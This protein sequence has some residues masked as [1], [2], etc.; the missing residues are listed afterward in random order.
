MTAHLIS[1]LGHQ[2]WFI[3]GLLVLGLAASEAARTSE[4]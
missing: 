4:R 3:A 2:W 1:W